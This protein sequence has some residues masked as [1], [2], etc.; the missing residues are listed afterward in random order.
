MFTILIL[1]SY[2]LI[3]R[4]AFSLVRVKAFIRGMEGLIDRR[5][6]RLEMIDSNSLDDLKQKTEERLSRKDDPVHLI[7]AVGSPNMEIA[8]MLTKDI[9][10]VY[11][12][13]HPEG[14]F[15]DSCREE[16]IYGMALT[17]PFTSNYKQYRFIKKLF[18]KAETVYVPFFEGT[19][20]CKPETAQKHADYRRENPASNWIDGLSDYIGFRALAGLNYIIGMR[21]Q[22]YV[23]SDALEL[24]MALS[25]TDAENSVLMVYNDTVYCS[26][27]IK[28]IRRFAEKGEVPL[29]WNN[30]PEAT[31]I[32]AVAALAGCFQEAGFFT[33]KLAAQILLNDSLTGSQIVTAER[34]FNSINRSQAERFGVELSDDMLSRFHEV[35]DR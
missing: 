27:A 21:Y 25:E 32:G 33:G 10:I 23:Y 17:L 8:G 1:N 28:Q 13:A 35:I 11:Y 14:V 26:G 4:D 6:V 30:N 18:P 24:E 15:L 9:P 34:E 19:G 31:R 12:G 16:N 2:Q 3:Q 20:F 22:E 29:I 7:H 5:N